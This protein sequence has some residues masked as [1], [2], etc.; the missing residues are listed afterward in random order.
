VPS[1]RRSPAPRAYT[2]WLHWYRYNGTFATFRI[3]RADAT[4]GNV[5][6]AIATAEAFHDQV[7]IA[8]Q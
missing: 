6:L 8:V 5:P 7:G 1:R 4:S 2:I 3:A